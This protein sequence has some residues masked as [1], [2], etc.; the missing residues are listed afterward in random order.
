MGGSSLWFTCFSIGIILSVARN[1]EQMEGE[2]L[3]QPAMQ[4]VADESNI[5][6]D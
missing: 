1:V 3:P 4:P 5:N 2:N 6:T